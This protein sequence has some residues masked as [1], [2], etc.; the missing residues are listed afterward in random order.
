MN[1]IDKLWSFEVEGSKWPNR[2]DH[3]LKCSQVHWDLSISKTNKF[4]PRLAILTYSNKN[5]T[6]SNMIR[7]TPHCGHHRLFSLFCWRSC[8]GKHLITR[9]GTQHPLLG[10]TYATSLRSTHLI[11]VPRNI[12]ISVFYS[13]YF[14]VYAWSLLITYCVHMNFI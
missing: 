13:K 9:K 5:E 1:G 11:V 2:Q 14:L 4:T 7:A 3:T 10:Y 8:N 12:V 6:N